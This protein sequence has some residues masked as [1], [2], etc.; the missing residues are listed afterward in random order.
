MGYEWIA[1]AAAGALQGA[2]GFVQHPK[3]NLRYAMKL[4]DYNNQMA[5]ENWQMQNEY[6]SPAAQMERYRAA[7]LNPNLI[8][9]QQN[10]GG[11]IATPEAQ[12][13]SSM[14]Q[15]EGKAMA[16][17]A[18]AIQTYQ[19][20]RG[21]QINNDNAELAGALT[22][23]RTA[24]INQKT[25]HDALMNAYSL[26]KAA[27]D[28]Q[29][30]TWKVQYKNLADL[31]KTE[32]EVQNNLAKYNNILA[33]TELKGEQRKKVVQE[34]K[35]LKGQL[36]LIYMKKKLTYAQIGALNQQM[37]F[38]AELQ[39]LMVQQAGLRNAIYGYQGGLLEKGLS[40]YDSDRAYNRRV[41]FYDRI[42]R[43]AQLGINAFNATG[44]I[45]DGVLPF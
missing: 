7:G 24:S 26:E 12:F 21:M 40:N 22:A 14:V 30:K 35:N 41:D 18:A 28:V 6:D 29:D 31:N 3:K 9:G 23:A 33:D 27:L 25:S 17:A 1:A 11:S 4:A 42:F 2:S 45:L 36:S 34:V 5:R 15:D 39:P 44:K 19:Q 16:S 10:T 20:I 43:G 38:S 32:S 37:R 8:Y 13:D